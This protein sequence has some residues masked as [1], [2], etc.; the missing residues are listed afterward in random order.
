METK[1]LS[2]EEWEIFEIE[3]PDKCAVITK[4]SKGWIG[5][6]DEQMQSNGLGFDLHR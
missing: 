4:V 6:C 5:N 3:S 1:I 2:N